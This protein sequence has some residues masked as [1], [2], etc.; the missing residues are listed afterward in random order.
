M[1]TINF[2]TVAPRAI[3]F[4]L[5]SF[6]A[7]MILFAISC[8]ESTSPD[9]QADVVIRTE[10][11]KQTLSKIE[12]K[13]N[14]QLQ[15]SGVDSLQIKKVRI[16]LKEIKFHKEAESDDSKDNSFKVGPFVFVGDSTGAYF[17]LANGTIPSGV[18]SK[19]KFEIHRFS[20]SQLASYSNN[21]TFIDFADNNRYTV[22]IEGDAFKS[23]ISS[24][25]TFKSDVT[26]N[27]SLKFPTSIVLDDVDKN[28]I[29]LQINPLDLLKSGSFVYDPKDTTNKNEIDKL[30]K[31][32]I[33]AL[34][35]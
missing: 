25:F 27:I 7:T 1:K 33:K 5:Y 15:K 19:I 10:L 28:Y 29:Y 9:N 17:D 34:K 26:E 6:M 13:D 22:I 12:L 21:A 31:S 4:M 16:L 24:R 32:A 11:T 2:E 20:S 23:G 30:I 14:E 3:K 8:S 35:K 18:Y